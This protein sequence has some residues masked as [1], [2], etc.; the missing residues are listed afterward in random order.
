MSKSTMLRKV[1]QVFDYLRFAKNGAY[2]PSK[3]WENRHAKH[4]D[5]RAVANELEPE[6]KRYEE[7]RLS[8]LEFLHSENIEINGK[9][10][11]EFGSGNGFWAQTVLAEG[12]S[13]YLGF[14]ISETAV[15]RCASENSEGAKFICADLSSENVEIEQPC[16]IG[17]SIDVTQ[18]IVSEEKLEHFLLNLQSSVTSGGHLIVTTYKGYGDRYI[19]GEEHKILAGLIK[20]PKLRWVHTWDLPTIQRL[21]PGCEYVGMAKFWDKVILLFRVLGD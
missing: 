20:I 13:Q 14:D 19:D 21:L 18:H 5:D 15:K 7:Q 1:K 11:L 16:D 8:F 2:D 17:F 6:K 3:Y 10:C 12:A 9:R 4:S